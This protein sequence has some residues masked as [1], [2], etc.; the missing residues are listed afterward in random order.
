MERAAKQA[1]EDLKRQGRYEAEKKA[2]EEI[3]QR[4]LAA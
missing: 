3:R 4:V 2:R 1:T